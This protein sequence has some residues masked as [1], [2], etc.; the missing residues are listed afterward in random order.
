MGTHNPRRLCPHPVVVVLATG[1]L[2]L[3]LTGCF[4]RTV[5]LDPPPAASDHD[6][7]GAQDRALVLSQSAGLLVVEQEPNVPQVQPLA[8][9]E[10]FAEALANDGVFEHVVFPMSELAAVAAPITMELSVASS[11]D[12]HRFNN[13]LRD[14]AT[15]ASLLLLQPVLPTRYDLTLELTLTVGTEAGRTLWRGQEII[16]SRFE[17]NWL[18]PPEEA[19]DV[20]YRETQQRAVAALV[21]RL[22]A[23]RGEL[24][25]LSSAGDGQRI[26][27]R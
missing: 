4:A 3:G 14:L 8:V 10:D 5:A 21:T 26:G 15:G 16:R 24:R 7:C 6:C 20:W 25:L 19:L 23:K 13:L 27:R 2:L 18:R 12:F 17:Y 22:D 9:A 1:L 11:F